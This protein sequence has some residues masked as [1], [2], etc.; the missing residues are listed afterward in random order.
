MTAQRES[1]PID[2]L[3]PVADVAQLAAAQDAVSRVFIHDSLVRYV[4]R[5][6]AETRR[7]PHAAW[8]ASPRGA[9]GLLEQAGW[10]KRN[11]A[12]SIT[13]RRT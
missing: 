8:G 10:L 5:V 6:V 11:F 3:A 2:A 7:H 4:Q 12:S 13:T 1:H 9:L